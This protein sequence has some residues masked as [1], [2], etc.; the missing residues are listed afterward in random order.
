[1]Y[2]VTVLCFAGRIARGSAYVPGF[3]RFGS[4]AT[5]EKYLGFKNEMGKPVLG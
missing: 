5:G 2:A 3:P 1:M 4:I